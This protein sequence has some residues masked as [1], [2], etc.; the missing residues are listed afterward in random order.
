M[1]RKISSRIRSEENTG[2]GTNS[3]YNAGRFMK[4][5]GTPNIVKKGTGILERYSW[6]HTF[7]GMSRGK[8]LLVLLVIYF[9]L[10]LSFATIY[11]LLGVE[12]LNGLKSG[13]PLQN[14]AEAFFFSTQTFTTVGY[15]RISPDGLLASSIASIEAFMG[16]L[17]FAIATGLFYGRFS[18]PQAFIRFSEI[19]VI[20]P[21]KGITALMF[22]L[23]PYK[24][25]N[26]LD[27]EVKLTL[28]TKA[29][30]NGKLVNKFYGLDLEI[31][32][33]NALTTAWTVVHPI[34]ENSPL[35]GMKPEDLP[36]IQ[37]E[38]MAFVKAFDDTY[39]NTVT[40]RT[41]YIA[42]KIRW[43]EKFIIMYGPSA[44][45]THTE[46]YIDRINQTEKADLPVQTILPS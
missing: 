1:A 12:N 36:T 10:N 46:L 11:Y 7:L 26:L 38:I 19:A 21:Y 9:L 8:F 43:G 20:A 22:R 24:N 31:S 42:N 34:N 13:T 37:P 30:E 39:S 33:V 5:D 4:A 18:R 23:V 28:A 16:L 45:G 2:F 44:D 29:D 15:G 32:K 35:F 3:S 17:S 41:S 40:A 27:A 25:N 14:F 6:Y